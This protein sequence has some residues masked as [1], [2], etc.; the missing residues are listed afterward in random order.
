MPYTE[1]KDRPIY[2]GGLQ[3]LSEAFAAVGAGD[4]DLNYVLTKVVIAWLTYQQPPYNYVLRGRG[5]L[6][7]HA[8]AQ[9]YY[10]RVMR[11]YEDKK[12]RENGDV[13]PEELTD[14]YLHEGG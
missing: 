4:G 11:P 12:I 8:A 10:D 9:E 5:L 1:Q 14:L 3:L 6:A 7:L 13:Y 2:D